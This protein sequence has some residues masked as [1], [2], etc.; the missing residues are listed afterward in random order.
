MQATCLFLHLSSTAALF[1][2]YKIEELGHC[3]NGK[4]APCVL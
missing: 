4:F 1:L 2:V 3:C